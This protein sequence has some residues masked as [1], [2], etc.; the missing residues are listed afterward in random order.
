[1]AFIRDPPKK[2]PDKIRA[3]WDS[4]Q[5]KE[6]DAR[7]REE[8]FQVG[9]LI[10]I[11]WTS[12]ARWMMMRAKRDATALR[13]ALIP[14]QADDVSKPTMPVAAAKKLMNVANPNDSGNM[15][16]MLLLHIGMRIRLLDSLD[17]KRL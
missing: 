3:H 2:I 14:V 16:G 9:H 1:M 15:H 4:I 6:D 5:L 17:E 7:F 13:I 10:G 12:V 8:R 11:Y